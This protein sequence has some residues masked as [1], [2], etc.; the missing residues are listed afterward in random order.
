MAAVRALGYDVDNADQ[1]DA[2]AI[3]LTSVKQMGGRRP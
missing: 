3:L 1:A 2:V